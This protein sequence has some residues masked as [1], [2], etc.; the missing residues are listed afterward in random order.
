MLRHLAEAGEA[1]MA[2]T[3][4]APVRKA[5]AG[6]AQE[7]VFFDGQDEAHPSTDVATLRPQTVDDPGARRYRFPAAELDRQLGANTLAGV[8]GLHE[9]DYAVEDDQVVVDMAQHAK[10]VVPLLLDSRGQRRA[11]AGTPEYS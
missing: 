3:A 1:S 10:P 9:V 7:A 8:L 6:A 11:I 5:T 4:G 2:I